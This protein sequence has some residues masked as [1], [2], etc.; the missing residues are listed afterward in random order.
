LRILTL[1]VDER[2]RSE[3]IWHPRDRHR[4]LAARAALRAILGDY[5]GLPPA[6]LPIVPD[7]NGKPR[8]AGGGVCFNLAHDGDLAL[9]AVAREREVGVDLER[10][11]PALPLEEL[12]PICLSPRERRWLDARPRVHQPAAFA[13][14]WV[15]KEAY[16]KACGTGLDRAPRLVEVT[17]ADTAPTVSGEAQI[18]LTRLTVGEDRVAALAVEGGALTLD[19]LAFR[20]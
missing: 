8:L 18:V 4:F 17:D 7:R 14:C 16:L 12:A 1:S 11:D 3:R 10:V 20:W 13:A 15:A 19:R 2:R 9:V 5:L 6:M